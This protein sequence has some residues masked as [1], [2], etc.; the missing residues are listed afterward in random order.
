MKNNTYKK[1]SIIKKMVK[2]KSA[3]K[4]NVS[5]MGKDEKL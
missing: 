2:K 4:E 5:L 1:Q 3:Q